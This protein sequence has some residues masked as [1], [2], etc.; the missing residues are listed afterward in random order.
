MTQVSLGISYCHCHLA[1]VPWKA[2]LWSDACQDVCILPI[3]LH[4]RWHS[5]VPPGFPRVSSIYSQTLDASSIIWCYTNQWLVSAKC[6]NHSIWRAVG[7]SGFCRQPAARWLSQE[8]T[9]HGSL[10]G[11]S[12]AHSHAW[13]E[14]T[15][16]NQCRTLFMTLFCKSLF[17]LSD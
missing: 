5:V 13:C 14:N 16:L 11:A 7:I 12:T 1:Q 9:R 17:L 3:L 2:A 4:I 6:T 15:A 10:K 8:A